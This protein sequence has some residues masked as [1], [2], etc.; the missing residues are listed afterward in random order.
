MRAV[1]R[2]VRQRA[3]AAHPRVHRHADHGG[4]HPHRELDLGVPDD[5]RD[6]HRRPTWWWAGKPRHRPPRRGCRGRSASCSPTSARST[7]TCSKAPP[8]AQLIEAREKA[9][10]IGQGRRRRRHHRRGR[11]PFGHVRVPHRSASRA[12]AAPG[13]G[14]V[15]CGHAGDGNVHLAVFQQGP[16]ETGR[17]LHESSRAAMDLG[18]AISGEHG[19][20]HAKSNTSWSS[21]T[22]PS[23]T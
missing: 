13:R 17:L 4:D 5:V 22:P 8:R 11:A 23:S 10:W 6:R 21:R 9:F 15:G 19:I 12:L 3:R 20:G 14:V 16:D 18:G 2:I 1:P 7:S